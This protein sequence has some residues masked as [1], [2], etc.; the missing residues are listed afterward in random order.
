MGKG[1]CAIHLNIRSLLPKIDLLRAWLVYNNPNII[2]VSET[3]LSESTLD[4]DIKL[5]NYVVYR[6]DRGAR[7]G[8]VCTYISSHLKSQRI[9]PKMRPDHFESIFVK[10]TL[11]ANK[12]LIIGNI[13]RP[14]SSPKSESV[15]NIITTLSSLGESH[16]I[17]LM[18][19]FNLNWMDP[20][21]LAERNM[22]NGAN[23]TQM[24]KEPTRISGNSK[25]L[26]DWILVTHPNRI[27]KSGILSD[28]FSDHSI[29]HCTWKISTPRLPPKFITTREMKS[30]NA[31]LYLNDLRMI[32]WDR[33]GL[34]P[35]VELAWDFF[36]S[37]VLQIIDKHAPWKIIKVKGQHLPWVNGDLINLF[38]QR[39]RAWKKYKTSNLADDWN[40]Y[41][42]LR[43][44]CTVQT[45]NAKAN[46][47]RNNLNNSLN[48][49]KQFWRKMN[50]LLGKDDNTSVN[51]IINNEIINDPD[52]ISEA[53]SFHFS[54]TPKV[55]SQHPFPNTV[56]NQSGNSSFE[57]KP[58]ST[59]DIQQAIN[60]LSSSSGPG[61][62]GIEAKF[63][64]IASFVI[65]S[66]LAELFNMSFA[67]SYVP[68][69]WKC[70]KVIP[71][72]KGGDVQNISNYRPISMIN[73][74]VKIFE[75]L[76]FDQ[77]T[78]Y[79]SGNNLLSQCQ[80][81]FRKGFFHHYSPSKIYK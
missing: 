41:K 10:V 45:R 71:L 60:T 25:S 65:S 22:F 79:L 33:L 37:E 1:L 66:P 3:W 70:T 27:I 6:E 68:S 12:Q 39:D 53:F 32:N 13:Y 14:P 56:L 52:V 17:I 59:V 9:F 81:G 24:I 48:N 47:F 29:I 2:T 18:G 77:L 43:N 7:G 23:L 78:E 72:H 40:E 5:E 36:Y 21:T 62:D 67:Y 19:D 16:E 58:I 11:H 31:D 26:I 64:K 30:F 69:A 63:L 35:D 44:L 76:I 8:G 28:C 42:R 73:S 55:Q 57:F 4:R 50:S 46:Y 49:P 15:R 61:P 54:Q 75:K 74:V 34:I 80:S 51:M 38:K 20:L